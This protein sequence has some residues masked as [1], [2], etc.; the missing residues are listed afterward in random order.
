MAFNTADD[1]LGREF[2]LPERSRLGDLH[3]PFTLVVTA[4]N[5]VRG[6]YV[7]YKEFKWGEWLDHWTWRRLRREVLVDT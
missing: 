5:P 3:G 7:Y 4:F 2:Q 1:L 6:V